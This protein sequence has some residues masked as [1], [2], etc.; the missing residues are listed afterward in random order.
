MT[1]PMD[2][3]TVQLRPWPRPSPRLPCPL[4]STAT[5]PPPS[6]REFKEARRCIRAAWPGLQCPLSTQPRRGL[7]DFP[8]Q[9]N[10]SEKARLSPTGRARSSDTCRWLSALSELET[11]LHFRLAPVGEP[12][13]TV[14]WGDKRMGHLAGKLEAAEHS[15]GSRSLLVY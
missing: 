12:D 5:S 7:P 13:D 2:T 9:E 14:P 8:S 6:F 1:E 11:D 3:P 4:W 15:I 10:H